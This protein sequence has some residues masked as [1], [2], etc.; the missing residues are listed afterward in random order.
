MSTAENAED[1]DTNPSELPSA[2]FACSA[3]N[4]P[5]IRSVAALLSGR[6]SWFNRL[7]AALQTWFNRLKAA[8]QTGRHLLFHSPK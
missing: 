8:L 1:T 7:K 5:S 4:P 3:V 6:H 2:Y